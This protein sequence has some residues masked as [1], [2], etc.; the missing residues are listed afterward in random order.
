MNVDFN[1]LRLQAMQ[2]C[3]E[4]TDQLNNDLITDGSE[5]IITSLGNIK[6]TLDNLKMR[7]GAIG[8]CTDE[9]C[10]E[11][12]NVYNEEYTSKGRKMEVLNS[13]K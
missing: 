8:M 3:D 5:V 2:L 10:P 13:L 7:I 11:I 4:L 6:E 12:R 1:N 9:R